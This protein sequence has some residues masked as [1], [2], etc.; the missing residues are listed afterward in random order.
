M[1]MDATLTRLEEVLRLERDAIIRF[2]GEALEQSTDEKIGLLVALQGGPPPAPAEAARYEAL[3]TEL[4]H[5]LA[6]LSHGRACLREAIA[7]FTLGTS[8]SRAAARPGIRVH[9]TG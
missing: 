2:D 1:D 5:N 7:T 6:L 9:V 4:R 8:D 3:R